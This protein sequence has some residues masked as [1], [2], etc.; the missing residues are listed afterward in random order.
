MEIALINEELFKTY[1]PVREATE[2][3]EFLPYI[4]A[5]QKTYI[6]PVIGLPLYD[7][8]QAQI[9]LAD[10]T[11]DSGAITP[12]NKLLLHQI[13]GPLSMFAVYLGLPFQ[14][15]AILN[16]GVTILKSE[17]SEA[18]DFKSLGQLLN[19]V[20]DRGN[21]QAKFLTDFLRRCGDYPLYRPAT[22]CETAAPVL[23]NGGIYFPKKRRGCC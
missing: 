20:R 19:W 21:E 23:K 6:V 4:I 5:A 17:N 9:K 13:A 11:K 2:I 18:L 1:G 3:D 8:L 14:W 10:E 16:K 12:Q 15:A 22:G 7:E